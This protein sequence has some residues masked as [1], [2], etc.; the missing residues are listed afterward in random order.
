MSKLS[1]RC[2]KEALLNKCK[3]LAQSDA[4]KACKGRQGAAYG[5][6]MDANFDTFLVKHCRDVVCP[7]DPL[8]VLEEIA[9]NQNVQSPYTGNEGGFTSMDQAFSTS[10]EGGGPVVEEGEEGTSPDK[11]KTYL[12]AGI[13]VIVLLSIFRMHK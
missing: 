13:G 5:R 12:F 10:S 7:G 8:A 3:D 6:C 9:K 1:E 2:R 4:E 11:L